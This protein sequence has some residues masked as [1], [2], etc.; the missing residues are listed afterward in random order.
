MLVSTD[1]TGASVLARAMKIKCRDT[2][3]AVLHVLTRDLTVGEVRFSCLLIL[4]VIVIVWGSWCQ[5]LMYKTWRCGWVAQT[6]YPITV[7]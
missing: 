5:L 4:I 6:F 2:F 7:D 1:K 3:E